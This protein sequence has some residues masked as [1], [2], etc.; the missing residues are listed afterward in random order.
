MYVRDCDS[1]PRVQGSGLQ[2]PEAYGKPYGKSFAQPDKHT[3]L[4]AILVNGIEGFHGVQIAERDLVIA[5]KYSSVS[6]V[7]GPHV[8]AGLL[9]CQKFC[10]VGWSGLD[11]I[12]SSD[13]E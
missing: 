2:I 7:I 6:A 11:A 3:L 10:S 5:E 1:K 8:L 13:D 12:G 9:A 4:V